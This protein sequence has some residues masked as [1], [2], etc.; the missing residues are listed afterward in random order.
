MNEQTLCT[1]EKRRQIVAASALNG[2]DY[3]EVV[4]H[5]F[6]AP[7]LEDLRQ[8]TLL[9]TFL[10]PVAG[11]SASNLRIEGGVRV[12]KIAILW[13]HPAD[14]IPGGLLRPAEAPFYGGLSNPERVLVVRTDVYGDFSRYRLRLVNGPTDLGVPAGFDGQLAAEDFW[15]KVECASDFD[16][17]PVQECPEEQVEAPDIDYLAKDYESFRRLMLDRMSVLLPDWQER[18]PADVQIALVEALAY[19]ADHLS[20]YQD[21][22]ATEAYLGTA[23][24]RTSLR[25]HARLLDYRP[26]EGSNARAWVVFDVRNEVALD[27]S[28]EPIVL[29]SRGK[30]EPAIQP[31]SQELADA[32][33]EQP[34]VFELMHSATLYPAN[35]E[36]QFYTWGNTSCCL[37]AGST[38]ATLVDKDPPVVLVRG[39]ILIFEE[40]RSPTTGAE[41]DADPEHRH[42]VRLV[43]ATPIQDEANGNKKLVEIEWHPAD[44]L[45]FPV[46]ISALVR[47]GDADEILADISVAR[48][49]VVLADHG[50]TQVEEPLIPDTTPAR[51]RYRPHLDQGPLVWAGPPFDATD[52]ASP[53]SHALTTDPRAALPAIW[54]ASGGERWDARADLLNSDRFDATFV[55]E[56]EEDRVAHL[57]FG[58]DLFGRQPAVGSRFSATY[59]VGGGQMG[60]VGADTLTR[61]VFNSS[62]IKRV[63]NPMAARGGLDPEPFERVRS[64]A[65]QAFRVQERA[66]TEVD[67]ARIAERQAEIQKAAGLFRWTGSWYTTYLT[68]DRRGGRSIDSDFERAVRIHLDRYR[69]AGTDLEVNG[70]LFVPLDVALEICVKP[71]YFRSHVKQALLQAFGNQ[72]LPGGGRG[73]FHPDNFTFGQ[74]LYLSQ[75]NGAALAVPGVA[76]VVVTRFHRWGRQPDGELD[77]AVLAPAYLEILRLDNDPSF[78]ENGRIEFLMD[79]GL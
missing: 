63:R 48:G 15:F 41:A 23:H 60:N 11:L 13:A 62:D 21:A 9:V 68:V 25:R 78:P 3:I 35:Y 54:L 72:P 33:Q 79:G 7:G 71:G 49:N 32:L 56:M 59:R 43:K 76:S 46:C 36:M 18:N 6:D 40:V 38:R 2:I 66:V 10:K 57:R 19:V 42:A 39:D 17:R 1:D 52:P 8:R 53:A 22:V 16:C 26:H 64:Q 20:Y 44:A 30:V 27:V 75:L 55:V 50:M 37:P 31:A 69:M 74:P 14:A 24:R 5:D 67:Y 61:I 34:S 4:D 77:A 73:F 65:P 28:S 51:G 58:D 70:P 45:P 47:Q 29:L 12:T